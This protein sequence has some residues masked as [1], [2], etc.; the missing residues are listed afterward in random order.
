MF[1]GVLEEIHS[2]F[3]EV[4]EK[5]VCNLAE[6]GVFAMATQYVVLWT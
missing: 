6:T 1:S 3:P 2:D 4:L 5:W